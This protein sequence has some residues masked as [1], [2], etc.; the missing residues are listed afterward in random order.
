M[1]CRFILNLNE[2]ADRTGRDGTVHMSIIRF[3][4]DILIGNLGESL[5]LGSDEP[6][7]D[8]EDDN[9]RPSYEAHGGDV[10]LQSLRRPAPNA[11]TPA[12]V[13]STHAEEIV[14][15]SMSF[16]NYIAQT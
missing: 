16:R 12:F 8:V 11:G 5:N 4:S 3:N 14:E 2:A 13:G 9:P 10:E 6:E 1:T 7:L 15:V